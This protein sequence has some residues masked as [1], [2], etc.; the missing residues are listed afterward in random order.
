MYCKFLSNGLAIGYDGTVKPCCEFRPTPEWR[1]SH[2]R[3]IVDLATWH[4]HPDLANLRQQ[5]ANGQWPDACVG[6]KNVEESGR[7]DSLRNN[8]NRSYGHY[9]DGDITL[10]IRPGSTCNFACQTCWPE[11][12]SRVSQY[13]QQAGLIQINDLNSRRIEDFDFL[14]PVAKR[15]KNVV[16]LGGEPFYDKACQRFIRWSLENL[17]SDFI[18]FTNGSMIDYEFLESYPGKIIL[19]FSLDSVGRSAEYIRFGTEWQEVV[20]NF[21]RCRSI[22]NVEFRVNITISVY[23]V[24]YL[25]ELLDFLC[26][27]WPPVVSF[28]IPADAKF[29]ELVIPLEF[30]AVIIDRL[31]GVKQRLSIADIEDGQKSNTINAVTSI[32]DRLENKPWDQVSYDKFVEYLHHMDR[33]KGISVRDYCPELHSMLV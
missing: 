18:M 17:D 6:C 21:N 29:S 20:A 23:N 25:P 12:S 1:T 16:L 11:A 9:G 4:Q 30:R 7:F 14:L 2:N 28:G 33:V 19:V 3:K 32:I 13:L 10:E 15:I 24:W 27:Q 31:V 22:P 26:Q 8:G 5:L